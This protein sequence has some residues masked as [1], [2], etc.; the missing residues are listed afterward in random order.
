[1]SGEHTGSL[2]KIKFMMPI[3]KQTEPGTFLGDC[4]RLYEDMIAK[5]KECKKEML[6]E[7]E[8]IQACFEIASS[9][10]ER[11]NALVRGH[12]FA[13][14]CDEIFF[15][16]K[17]KPLFHSEVEFYTYC[18]HIV[19]FKTKEIEAD[20]Y[21]LESFYKRQLQRNEKMRKEFPAFYAYVQEGH[22]HADAQW[23]TRHSNTLDCSLYDS[24]MGRYLALEKFEDHLKRVMKREL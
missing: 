12:E 20:K 5:I 8:R 18:Y 4:I 19:L 23:F 10:K 11:L 1:V 15:F 13:N 6:H 14:E 9:Y 16:K 3:P 7:E 24:L 17:V 22:T 2:I 21:E